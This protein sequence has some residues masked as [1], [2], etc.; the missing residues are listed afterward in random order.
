MVRLVDG[1]ALGRPPYPKARYL[2]VRRLKPVR[3]LPLQF[4][5]I[6][7]MRRLRLMIGAVQQT[8][9]IIRHEMQ[10]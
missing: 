10:H 3:Y 1:T 7:G 6:V 8:N 5:R 4:A 9:Q 2:D